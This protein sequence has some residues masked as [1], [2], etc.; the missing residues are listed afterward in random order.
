MMGGRAVRFLGLVAGTLMAAGGAAAAPPVQ[1]VASFSIL[2]D[3]VREVGGDR[4]QVTSLVGPN[5]DVHV[6]EPTPRDA[7]AVAAADIVFVNGLGFEGWID[8]LVKSS[9]S[10]AK[11]V[12]ASTGVAVLSNRRF[13]RRGSVPDPHAWHSVANASVYVGNVA[14]G[15]CGVDAAGCPVYRANAARYRASLDT[16]DRWIRSEIGSLPAARRR[17]ITSHDA[18][19][20]FGRE[21]GVVFIA[22]QGVSTESE[23]SAGEV[24]RLIRDVRRQSA[25]A[26]FVENIS[27]PRLIAQIARETGLR[28]GGKLYSDALSDSAGE[29]ASYLAMMRHNVTALL[30]AMRGG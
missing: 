26:L 3:W 8:R 9:G 27:D 11:V 6:Y 25:G 15:L 19:A 30:A 23:P 1:A 10:A 14:D 18:F 17:V 4:V 29:A 12:T 28:P 21:Y 22:P 20:Y 5:G 16:L 13:D 24:A 2:A 7:R